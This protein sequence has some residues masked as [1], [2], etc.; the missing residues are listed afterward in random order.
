MGIHRSIKNIDD[1]E[2][3]DHLCQIYETEK[4]HHDLLLPFLLNGLKQNEKIIYI[5]DA[6]SAEHILDYLREAKVD[7]RKFVDS[8]Q[9]NIIT[10]DDAYLKQGFF[11]PKLMI[12]L[13]RTETDKAIKEGYTALRVTGEMTWALKKLPGSE[14]LI[15]YE[16]KL[17]EFFPGS[18]A[19]AICQYDKRIFSSDVLLN[20][21]KTHPVAVIGTEIYDNQYYLPPDEFLNQDS[22]STIFE[23]WLKNLTERKKAE[24]EKSRLYRT[25]QMLS[26]SNQALLHATDETNLFNDVCRIAVEVGGYLLAWI[27]IAE[28]DEAK[29]V[30]PVA[31]AG[32]DSGYINSANITWADN[33]RGRGP[34]GTAIRTGKPCIARN[35]PEDSTFTPW[36]EEA[37][38]RGFKSI[39]AMPLIADG[40]VFAVLGIYSSEADAFDD[41]EVSVL[42]ELAED[43]SFGVSALHTRAERNRAEEALQKA[44]IK[45]RIVAD[46]T[47][48]WEF[49]R[50]PT[51]EF[52]Y[53]SPSCKQITGYEAD[54]FC[55][56]KDLLERIIF[57]DDRSLFVAH[58]TNMIRGMRP[59]EIE[60]RIVHRDGSIKWIG[61]VCQPVFDEKGN[62]LGIRG[63]NRDITEGKRAEEERLLRSRFVESMDKVNRAIQGKSELN[64]MMSDVLETVLSIFD[65][66]RAWLFYPCDP[67]APSFR[68]PMEITKPEYPGAKVLNVDLP[69]PPEM[70]QNLR[71]ALESDDPLIYTVG[72]EKTVNKASVEQ[73]GVKSQMFVAIYPKLGKPWVFGLHQC[74]IPR[75]WTKEEKELFK[76]ISNR[77][78]D[79]LSSLLF[80]HDLQESE[81]KLKD[82]AETL[83]IRVSE[84]TKELKD[85]Q[86]QLIKKEKLA[87]LGELAGTVAHE[88]RSPLN[89]V[90]SSMYLI[91]KYFSKMNVEE[92]MLRHADLIEREVSHA[93]F[94]INSILTFSK[95]KDPVFENVFLR[96]ILDDCL[97]SFLM[98][99][100]YKVKNDLDREMSRADAD[101][102]HMRILFSNIIA[103][104]MDA[105]PEGGKIYIKGSVVDGSIKLEFSDTGCGIPEDLIDKIFEPLVSGKFYGTGFGL[106]TCK[107]IIEAHGGSISAKNNARGG[108]TFTILMPVR[109]KGDSV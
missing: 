73:F 99:E 62:F 54:E 82:W 77:I 86:E 47:Y 18:K 34:G 26:Q 65:C 15:E 48:D 84:R 80:L 102:S 1:L 28:Q 71:E 56:D 69:M 27:G 78:S 64:K 20:I 67:D 53:V 70:A 2:P 43:L 37:N 75:I 60:F 16:S 44:T 24:I 17:N 57:Q 61:H 11:D 4:E 45:Y 12:D 49:W 95:M 40:R 90:N 109:H 7:T 108:T 3:G 101:K 42:K 35:I 30:R 79:G 68:V 66:D 32:L 52:I 92:K 74:S 59:G 41:K 105:M 38:R 98:G 6:H 10:R 81:Q 14:R 104:S 89:T 87:L 72:T 63:S 76:E 88:L 96:D 19:L 58:H 83:E 106:S 21:L 25:V 55:A 8:G 107:N 100:K 94:I 29:T 97:H 91:R 31:H 22:S 23:F 51:D 5:V 9:L 50:S 33:P 85:A 36:R 93:N 13:L 39:I 103:N 46:N